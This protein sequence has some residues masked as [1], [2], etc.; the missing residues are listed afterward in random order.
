MNLKMEDL[1]HYPFQLC[2][3]SF[4]VLWLCAKL[5][6]YFLLRQPK[7]EKELRDDFNTILAATL[8]LLGLIIGFS[9]SMAANRYDLRRNYE[10]A[11]ANA[12]GTEY[13]R[14]ELL[15]AADMNRV[16]ALLRNYLE[17]RI[18]F[19]KA[20]SELEAVQINIHTAELQN[21]LWSAI[22][23]PATAQPNAVTALVVSG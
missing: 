1:P 5:G 6:H 19:Y 18:V 22:R 11:E 20:R 8:T 21:E 15:P 23:G 4:F 17:H 9:F 2:I 14:A 3:V 7:H 13:L 12:I 16:Q 10:E